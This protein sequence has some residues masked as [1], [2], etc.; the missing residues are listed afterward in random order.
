MIDKLALIQRAAYSRLRA[1]SRT[2]TVLFQ[3]FAER[4]TTAVDLGIKLTTDIDAVGGAVQLKT[5]WQSAVPNIT[6]RIRQH[7]IIEVADN[8]LGAINHQIVGANAA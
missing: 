1:F 6:R 7:H 8:D 5:L 4:K 3:I 2:K